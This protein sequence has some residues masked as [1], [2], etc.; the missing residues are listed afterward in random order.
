MQATITVSILLGHKHNAAP[1]LLLVLGGDGVAVRAATPV[2]LASVLDRGAETALTATAFA[3]LGS[4]ATVSEKRAAVERLIRFKFVNWARMGFG[5]TD[6]WIDAWPSMAL[7]PARLR[8]EKRYAN[9][10]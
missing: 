1:D 5:L 7:E 8:D 2:G 3:M 9:E 10:N 4:M 6:S